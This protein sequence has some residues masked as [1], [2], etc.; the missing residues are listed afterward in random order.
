MK[1]PSRKFESM[2]RAAMLPGMTYMLE[3]MQ[4][5]ID[6]LRAEMNELHTIAPH[7]GERIGAGRP[8]KIAAALG[9][10]ISVRSGKPITHPYWSKLTPEQRSA[11]M[12]KRQA[13]ALAKKA[14]ANH[15]RH[16]DHPKHAEWVEKMRAVNKAKWAGMSPKERK[17][18]QAVMQTAREKAAARVNGPEVTA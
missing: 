9:E 18:R 12:T 10:Q 11:E 3:L 5:Q 8:K 4:A 13:A 1:T 17:A 15:P 7:G 2:G 14:K 6:E 16:P